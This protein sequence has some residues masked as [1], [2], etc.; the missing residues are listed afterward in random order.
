[1][2]FVWGDRDAFD[3]PDRGLEL[4][5]ATIRPGHLV[6]IPDAGHLAWIDEPDLVASAIL[7]AVS[8]ESAGQRPRRELEPADRVAV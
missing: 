8:D 1:V 3:A 2:T 7:S 5:A 4:A 6:V